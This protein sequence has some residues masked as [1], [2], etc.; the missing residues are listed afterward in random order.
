VETK[1]PKYPGLNWA[2]E[3]CPGVAV[4]MKNGLLIYGERERCS[5]ILLDLVVTASGGES[6]FETFTFK[7][8]P[9]RLPFFDVD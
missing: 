2:V 7:F 1:F 9:S 4:F 5:D 3:F 8:K 6:K